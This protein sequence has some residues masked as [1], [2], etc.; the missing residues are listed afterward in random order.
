MT[1]DCLFDIADGSD[2]SKEQVMTTDDF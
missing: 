1:F 2:E